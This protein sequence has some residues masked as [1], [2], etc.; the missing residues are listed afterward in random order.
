MESFLVRE[1]TPPQGCKL[2]LPAGDGIK[3]AAA[4]NNSFIKQAEL[5]AYTVKKVKPPII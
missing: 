1:V 2:M 3:L 5:M 4:L